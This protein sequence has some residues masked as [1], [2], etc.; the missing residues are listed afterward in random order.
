M[1]SVL[2]CGC[3]WGLSEPRARLQVSARISQAY[4]EPLFSKYENS[5]PFLSQEI[6][7]RSQ[8]RWDALKR[9][10]RTF[11]WLGHWSPSL[12]WSWRSAA[13][14]TKLPVCFT[15]PSLIPSAWIG[16]AH[17]DAR[18]PLHAT[19]TVRA[20]PWTSKPIRVLDSVLYLTP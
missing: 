3:N 15:G 8:R 10:G 12:A 14:K 7:Q 11:S 9:H 5:A 6:V 1:G 13:G 20:I 18:L 16:E 17:L 4:P 19:P 2:F